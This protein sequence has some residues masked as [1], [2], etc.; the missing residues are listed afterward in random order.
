MPLW[1]GCTEMYLNSFAPP[2]GS[3]K[4]LMVL[5]IFCYTYPGFHNGSKMGLP[6]DLGD[7]YK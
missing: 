6:N 2:M 1:Y 5:V 3:Y 4:Y 7:N